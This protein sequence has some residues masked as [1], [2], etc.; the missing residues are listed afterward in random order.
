MGE[1]NGETGFSPSILGFLRL[2]TIPPL[3]QTYLPPPAEVCDSRGQAAPYQ[4]PAFKWGASTLT[5]H[6]TGRTLR[7]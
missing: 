1:T 4:N 3:L 6:L 7:T 2:S 5:L